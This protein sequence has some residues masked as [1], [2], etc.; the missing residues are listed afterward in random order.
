MHERYKSLF[1]TTSKAY[2]PFTALIDYLSEEEV[3]EPKKD[4]KKI[5][6]DFLKLSENHSKI[7]NLVEGALNQSGHG[8]PTESEF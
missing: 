5:K 1:D 3:K 2:L 6:E 7:K 8:L 4:A